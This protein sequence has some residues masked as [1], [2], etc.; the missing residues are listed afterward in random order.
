MRVNV[1]RE[2]DLQTRK[3]SRSRSGHSL[4]IYSVSGD[5]YEPPDRSRTLACY[6]RMIDK[7]SL[8]HTLNI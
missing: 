4:V 8:E 3:H 2:I 7:R 6:K 1:T 5:I